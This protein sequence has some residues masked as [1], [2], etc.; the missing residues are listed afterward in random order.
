[1]EFLDTTII[2]RYLTQDNLDQAQRALALLQ[3]V[4]EGKITVTTSEAVI[5]EAVYMLSSRVTYNLPALLSRP[6]WQTLSR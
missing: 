5:V 1:M 3:D 2:I 6:A 4:E